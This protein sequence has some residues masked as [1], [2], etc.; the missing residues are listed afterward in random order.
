MLTS[1]FRF[2]EVFKLAEQISPDDQ[3]VKFENV[4]SNDNGGVALICFRQGQKLDPHT[5]PADVMV[6]VVAGQITFNMAGEN[7]YMDAGDFMLMG[8]GVTHSV[9]AELPSK[10]MLV[11][12]KP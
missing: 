7:H 1:K 4:F 6:Y 9:K 10:V 11:K 2:G 8:A 12:V 5:A 3:Q